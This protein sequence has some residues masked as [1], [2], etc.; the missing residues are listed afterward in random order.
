MTQKI[1]LKNAH[2]LD[3]LSIL[4]Q[5]FKWLTN[6]KNNHYDS[7]LKHLKSYIPNLEH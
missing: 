3:D 7:Y 5:T 2:L 4:H 1:D 6:H